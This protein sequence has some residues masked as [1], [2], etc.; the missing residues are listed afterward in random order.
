MLLDY[1]VI[2]GGIVGVSTAMHLLERNPGGSLVL[3]EKEP[4]LARHQT[5][6]NSGVI[7]AGV[8]YA[9][10]SLK[11]RFSKEGAEATIRFCQEHGI[12]FERCGKLLVATREAEVERMAALHERCRQNEIVVER[13]DGA[14]LKRR[15]PHITGLGALFVPATGIV[16]YGLVTRR[17]A[18]RVRSQGGEIRTSMPVAGIREEADGVTV[19]AGG[20]TLRARVLV[21]CAGLMADRLARLCGIG[22]DFRIVPFRGEYYRL[23]P[24]RNDIVRHLIYPIPDPSLPFL[25]VHLTRMIG[26]FV[27]VGPNA[28]FS[29]KR[30]GYTRFA[31]DLKDTAEALSFPGTWQVLKR[32]G[33]SGLDE[34]KNSLSRRR[35]LELCRRYC[36]ELTLDDLLPHPSGVRAQAVLRDGTLVHDF[37]IERT[38]RTIHICNAPSP[39]ATSAIPIGQHVA[40]QAEAIM[41]EV[42]GTA[43]KRSSPRGPAAASA[44]GMHAG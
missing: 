3:L 42:G 1:L 35:Y 15:E 22:A 12:P 41:A 7:H 30:E 21:A 24:S 23:P 43:Q 20:E 29:F 18:E 26:G 6:R 32:H 39:A 5:G 37:L 44:A 33:R 14:E 4:D 17:M 28:V 38:N 31:F 19:T 16:D 8:Y 2:G 10:G 40:E 34:F 13:L 11:A 9:P 36:P 27:T 25:G